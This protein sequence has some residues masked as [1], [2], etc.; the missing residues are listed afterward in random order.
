MPPM[1]PRDIHN[2][3]WL[4]TSKDIDDTH[5]DGIPYSEKKK[6]DCRCP[7][8]G[9]NHVMSFHWIGGVLLEKTARPAGVGPLDNY[10][11]FENFSL[12]CL[13]IIRY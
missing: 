12:Q 13:L 10:S 4:S 7:K 3:A 8:C 5:F 1:K 2:R 9:Q 6:V 11:L